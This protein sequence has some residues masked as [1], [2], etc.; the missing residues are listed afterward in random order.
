MALSTRDFDYH[1]DPGRIAQEPLAQRD[2]SRLM[3]LRRRNGQ[4]SHHVFA[5]LPELLGP[6]DVLVLND[7]R[8][9]PAKFFCRRRTGASI[10]GLFLRELG[11][12]TWEVLLNS[13]GRCRI[14]EQLLLEG[15][16]ASRLVLRENA[17]RGRWRVD[18]LPQAPA[19]ALLQQAGATPL[20]PYIRRDGLARDAE[21]RRRYQTVYASAAGAV[22]APTAGLHFTQSLLDRLAERGIETVRVTLHVGLG[23]FA[24]VREKDLRRHTMH[25]E[26]YEL[27]QPSA[28]R[29]NDAR[30]QGK[31][32]VVVGTTSVRVLETLAA[33]SQPFEAASGWTDLFIYPPAVF[34]A[35]DALITNFHLPRSTLLMLVAA[36]C[37][38]GGTDGVRRILDAYGEADRMGYRFY[39]YGDAML[40]E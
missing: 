22:A 15:A 29:L 33:S 10:E 5:E 9:I 28:D 7:T 34:R 13:A 16:E 1:L 24:P 18:V 40:I 31:R 37:C 27:P 11:A 3:V 4:T 17:G 19:E 39:S 14:G 2:Q 36:F 38:P 6:R 20:P 21:D 30:K 8:V 35:T 23:T 32:I 25:R 12:G 26:W